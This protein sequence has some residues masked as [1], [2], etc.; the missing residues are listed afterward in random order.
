MKAH[1]YLQIVADR[2]SDGR[3]RSLAIKRVTARSPR[4]PLPGALI[5][6]VSIDVP[7]ELTHV[8]SVEAAAKAGMLTLVLEPGDE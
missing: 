8:Q 1:G 4:D 3:A 2:R 6:R 5:V 7:D